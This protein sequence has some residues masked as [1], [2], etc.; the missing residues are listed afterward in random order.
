LCPTSR[1]AMSGRYDDELVD[2][3]R[4]DDCDDEVVYTSTRPRSFQLLY[5]H[6]IT[7]RSIIIKSIKK[8]DPWRFGVL[9]KPP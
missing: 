8:P 5:A 9:L 3:L 4:A 2:E 6:A 1:Q 7:C